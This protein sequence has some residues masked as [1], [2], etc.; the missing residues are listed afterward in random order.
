MATITSSERS[1]RVS[2]E[3][4]G[5]S[6]SHAQRVPQVGGTDPA[7]RMLSAYLTSVVRARRLARYSFCVSDHV[8][9]A[10]DRSRRAPGATRPLLVSS[11]QLVGEVEGVGDRDDEADVAG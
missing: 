11:D 4:H 3:R 8:D 7:A 6:G 10:P 9:V 2:S 5:P 1:Y